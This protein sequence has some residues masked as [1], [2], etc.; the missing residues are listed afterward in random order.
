MKILLLM[1]TA[2]AA[3]SSTRFF[4]SPHDRRLQHAL[5]TTDNFE[6]VDSSHACPNLA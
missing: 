6:G 4:M 1:P 5:A 3:A 2:P